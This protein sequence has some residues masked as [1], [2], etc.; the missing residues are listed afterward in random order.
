[1]HLRFFCNAHPVA[2][3]LFGT[4]E[5]GIR[6]AQHCLD[7]ATVERTHGNS[8]RDSG[9]HYPQH[10]YVLAE[11]LQVPGVVHHHRMV[12]AV[13]EKLKWSM[14]IIMMASRCSD[15]SRY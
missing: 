1:M 3:F 13:V 9:R 2:A 5:D 6:R 14:S 7:R 10:G 12:M 15:D 4:I 11:T 8:H